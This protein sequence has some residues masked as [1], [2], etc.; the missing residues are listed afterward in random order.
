MQWLQHP[1][2]SNIYNLNNVR[3]EANR[4][5]RN[6]EKEYLKAKTDELETNSTTKNITDLYSGINDFKRGY[7]PRSNT[8]KNEKGELITDSH[9]NLAK[10]RNHFSQ[11]L[12]VHVFNDVRQTETQTLQPLV[13]EPSAFQ[14]ELATGKLKSHRSP[15]TAQIPA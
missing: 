8:V 2:Q 7:Q 5:F 12:N 11:L 15:G 4:H 3:C 14:V 1:N 13:P 9:S 10:W 6:K